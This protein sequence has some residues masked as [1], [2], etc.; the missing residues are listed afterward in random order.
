MAAH[1][2]CAITSLEALCAIWLVIWVRR[3]R[4]RTVARAAADGCFAR[5]QIPLRDA[6]ADL[7]V[8]RGK[9]AWGGLVI[10]RVCCAGSA[11]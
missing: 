11:R 10:Q 2:S 5:G 3:L 8:C 6:G 4:R 1:S 9:S 7:D